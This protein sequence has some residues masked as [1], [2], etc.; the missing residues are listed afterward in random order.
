MAEIFISYKSERRP[1]AEHLATVLRHHGHEVWFDYQLVKGRDFR[2]QIEQKIREAK[3]LVALWCTRSVSSRWVIEEVDLAHK[4][5][6]LVPA[7]IEPCELPFGYR[8]IDSID[9][10][11]WDGAPRGHHLDRLLDALEQR[12]G[13]QPVSDF[14]ALRDYDA[15]WRRLGALPLSA[16]ALDRP[17][18]IV[19]PAQGISQRRSM[20]EK[21]A[22]DERLPPSPSED[23]HEALPK[24]PWQIISDKDSNDPIKVRDVINAL[25]ASQLGSYARFALEQLEA[26][27]WKNLPAPR[28]EAVLEQFLAAGWEG[29]YADQARAELR[30]LKEVKA[31]RAPEAAEKA[32]GSAKERQRAADPWASRKRALLLLP[33]SVILLFIAGNQ[34][35]Q[36]N[37]LTLLSSYS[38]VR[39]EPEHVVKPSPAP[40]E[41]PTSHDAK[42]AE[43][44]VATPATTTALPQIFRDCADCPEMVV[45]PAGT[46]LMGSPRSE[47]GRQDDEG[48]HLHVTIAQPFAA[49]RFEVTFDEWAACVA[50]KGCDWN[51]DDGGWGRGS[52]PVINV[53]WDD[54]QEY[55]K[56]LS[57]RTGMN[58]RLLSEAEWEYAARAGSRTAYPW[59]DEIDRNRGNCQECGWDRKQTALVGSFAANAFGLYDM[60]GN[61]KEWVQDCY[62]SNYVNAPSNGSAQ[63]SSS[64]TFRVLRGG[65]WNT[66]GQY[67]RSAARSVGLPDDRLNAIGFRVSR[68]L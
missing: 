5:G 68:T 21:H 18:E 36:R 59:G 49:G 6:I 29:K 46:F 44:T 47:N 52:R 1:A 14:K 38:T 35:I 26:E 10:S 28:T 62:V 8:M 12:I 63:S 67:L 42:S 34:E 7:M 24:L 13:R 4:L 43:A 31:A 30:G 9:I 41:P 23:S 65:S 3:A 40:I 66:S 55:V 56:W 45:V 50:D 11:S 58:Y 57:R 39:V 20:Q 15:V 54:A 51:P 17:I 2:S 64:C 25:K 48:P 27:V 16:F 33:G 53:S 37:I 22:I 19:E 61:V 32:E 60:H